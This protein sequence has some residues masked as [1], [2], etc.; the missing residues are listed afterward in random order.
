M[1]TI[2]TFLTVLFS[3]LA[4]TNAKASQLYLR[5]TQGT[6]VSAII[7]GEQYFSNNGEIRALNL[8]P[9]NH[10]ITIKESDIRKHRGYREANHR[11]DRVV[12]RGRIHIPNRS[13]V[14]ARLNHRGGLIIDRVVSE[15][16]ASRRIDPQVVRP[17][18]PMPPQHPMPPH[19]GHRR[20]FGST[21]VFNT[22]LEM[23]KNASFD[24][25]K[26]AI[27]K[28]FA[29]TNDLYSDEVLALT[30]AFDFESSKLTFA[31]LAYANTLDKENY[32]IVNKAFDFSSSSIALNMFI[33]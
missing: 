22:A 24:S 12:Y 6:Y 31:K 28:Q 14:Y 16:P 10:S 20:E 23:V 25:Q 5:T 8:R 17:P 33:S 18:R 27:A 3:L 19:R 15:R 4:T 30:E 29:S 9:G 32:F 11:G 26:M 2:T 21:A 13:I 1:K 7:S